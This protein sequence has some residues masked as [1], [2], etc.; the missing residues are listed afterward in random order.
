MVDLMLEADSPQSDQRF[1]SKLTVQ[2]V[3]LDLDMRVPFY[4]GFK[5]RNG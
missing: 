1:H 4:L 5:T 2:I 3:V